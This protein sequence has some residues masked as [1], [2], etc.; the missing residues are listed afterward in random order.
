MDTVISINK[1]DISPSVYIKS[2]NFVTNE[3]VQHI[4]NSDRLDNTLEG[5]DRIRGVRN[6]IEGDNLLILFYDEGR[7]RNVAVYDKDTR[8]TE[9][10]RLLLDDLVFEIDMENQLFGLHS[11]FMFSDEKGVYSVISG[12]YLEKFLNIIKE[13]KLSLDEEQIEQLK[14]LNEDSNPVLFYYEY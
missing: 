9:V 13:N 6:F 12:L 4:L 10:Y 7:S 14:T 5:D 8:E 3:D 2:E 1:N 11:N